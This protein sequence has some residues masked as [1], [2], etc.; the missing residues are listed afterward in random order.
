MSSMEISYE[1]AHAL[2]C[3]LPSAVQ[4]AT[5]VEQVRGWLRAALNAIGVGPVV[6]PLSPPVGQCGEPGPDGLRCERSPGHEA[7]IGGDSAAHAAY[8]DDP[9]RLV[10]W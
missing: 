10:R 7:G 6:P 1:L 9:G 8:A 5:E 4:D 3:E 2:W